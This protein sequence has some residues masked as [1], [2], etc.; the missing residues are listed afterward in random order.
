MRVAQGR[1]H[2][3]GV[4]KGVVSGD[5]CDQ[6]NTLTAK[7]LPTARLLSHS[8]LAMDLMRRSRV[9]GTGNRHELSERKS[10]SVAGSSDCLARAAKCTALR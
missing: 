3:N 6:A 8:V 9:P 2:I 5:E 7:A 1:R 4:Q 10:D